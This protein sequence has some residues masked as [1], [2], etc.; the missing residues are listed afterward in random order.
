LLL[1]RF[2]DA[3]SLLQYGLAFTLVSAGHAILL[4]DDDA[5]KTEFLKVDHAAGDALQLAIRKWTLYLN[6]GSSAMYGV[7]NGRHDRT[8]LGL[9]H[10]G[11]LTS[12]LMV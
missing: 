2:Y 6:K 1:K 5:N 7:K 8:R 12:G 3:R 4:D 9:I 10:G 11:L